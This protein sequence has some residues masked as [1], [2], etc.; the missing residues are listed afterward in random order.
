[1]PVAVT[2][3]R[4]SRCNSKRQVYRAGVSIGFQQTG[5]SA[6]LAWLP[7]QAVTSVVTKQTGWRGA[8]THE[9]VRKLVRTE[10]D[11]AGHAGAGGEVVKGLHPALSRPSGINLSNTRARVLA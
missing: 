6:K 9:P 2:P 1:M 11:G 4:N 3:A 5:V 7:R 10:S 8:G